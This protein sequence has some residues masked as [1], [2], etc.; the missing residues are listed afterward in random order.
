M[1]QHQFCGHNK[2]DKYERFQR[3]MV[4]KSSVGHVGA[5]HFCDNIVIYLQEDEEEWCVIIIW[6]WRMLIFRLMFDMWWQAWLLKRMRSSWSRCGLVHKDAGN[7]GETTNKSPLYIKWHFQVLEICPCKQALH[8]NTENN[9]TDACSESRSILLLSEHASVQLFS[10]FSCR[11]C[12]QGHI[13][14]TWKCHLIYRGDLFVVSPI[15]PASLWTRPHLD[16]DDL[17]LLSNQACHH[18]SNINLNIS[19]LHNQIIITHHSSSSSWR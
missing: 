18:M 14:N 8:E 2:L 11:A 19:I 6:L 15:F 12:L 3:N 7:M 9:W 1:I 10:V 4:I 5:K 13:S 16:H 17:I